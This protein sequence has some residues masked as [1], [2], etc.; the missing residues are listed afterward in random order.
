MVRHCFLRAAVFTLLSTSP[1]ICPQ[2][3]ANDWPTWRHD[4]L[5]TGVTSERVDPPLAQVWAFRSRQARLSPKP[6]H[7]PHQAKYPWL[8]WYTLPITA[9]GDGLFFN[10]AA[11]GRTVCLD[12]AT[13]KVRWEFTAGAAVNRT[14]MIWQHK[15]YVGSDDGHVYCL[16]A[17]AGTVVW[18]FKAAPADRWL[19]CY[20]KPVSV[21]PVRTDVLVDD[22]VAYFGAGVFPHD[23]TLLYAVDAR[24]GKLL[25]RNGTQCETGWRASMAPAGHLFVTEKS[26]WVPKDCWGYFLNWGTLVAFDR[27]TG[28]PMRSGPDKGEWPEWPNMAGPFWPVFGVRK[29]GVRYF[30]THASKIDDKD[31]NKQTQLWRQDVEGRWTDV[32][33][34]ISVRY[35]NPVF[36]RY[37]PDLSTVVYA[38]GVLYHTALDLDPKKGTASGI[39]ARDPASGKLLWS[40]EVAERAN[41]LIVA[42]GRLF[43]ATRQGTIYAFAPKGA[44]EYGVI[45]EAIDA[46]A[47][48][49][50][51]GP[52]PAET[53]ATAEAIIKETG[54]EAG[55]ALVVDCNRGGLALEL[56]KRTKLYVVAAFPDASNAD[57]ARKVYARANLHV[58]RIVAYHQPPGTKLPLPSF[59][60]DLVVSEAATGGGAL[61]Q[62]AENLNR[63]LKPIRGVALIGGKQNEG[64]LGEW[65]AATKQADWAIVKGSSVWAKRVRPRLEEAGGWFHPYGD[66]GHSNC[67]R[68][69]ALKPPLGV[70]WYGA[71]HLGEGSGSPGGDS[72]VVDGILLLPEGTTLTGYDQYTGR[73]LWRRENGHT[74]TVAAPGSV[75]LRYLEV[76]IQI[77]PATGRTLQEYHPP[78]T[79]GK[80]TAMAA[81]RDGKT[82]YLAAGGEQWNCTLAMDVA[83]GK[84]RWTLGGPGKEKQW[85]AWSAIGDGYIYFGGGEAEGTLREEVIAEMRAY[86][87]AD[88]PKRLEKFEEELDQHEFRTFTTVDAKTGKVLYTHGMDATNCGGKWLPAVG[89][90]GG[91]YARHYNPLVFGC[92]IAQKDVVIF[93]TASG[94][95]KGWRQWPAGAYS[96]RSIAVHDGAT[97]KLLWKKPADY[98]TRPVVVDDTIYAEPWAYDLRT[99]ERKTRIHP[100]TGKQADWA[101]CRSDKQC[102]IFSAS[103]HFLFGRSL[104]VGYHDLLTDQGLYTFFHS[105]MS[106]SFDALSGGGLMIKPPMA[107]YCKCSWSLP[108]T[109]ALGQVPTQPTVGQLYAQPGPVLP[110]KHL[111]V[112]FGATG[113]RRDVQGDLWLKPQRPEGHKLLLGFGLTV[114]MYPGGED[115]RRNSLYTPIENTEVPFVFATAARG[116]KRCIIP[117]T[118]S[119]DGVG[120]F[121]VK[122]GFAA[123][124]GDKPGRRVFDVKLNGKTVL[125]DFDVVKEAGRPDV[126]V[127]KDFVLDLDGD[128]VLDLVARSDKPTAEQMPL[129]N[130]LVIRRQER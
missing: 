3:R 104:G 21:W 96:Q 2:G 12:A 77:D 11:D 119:A 103:K 32:D 83:G 74:D 50:G 126:A 94:A 78:F 106:C 68:D 86:L 44:K 92:T 18:K 24:T 53:A 76:V 48:V 33:S 10:S 73:E 62:D 19:L 122:L 5:R 98:R 40:A 125:K 55:Y 49:A 36:F 81:D 124:P 61:P 25:W 91:R 101:W 16:D 39:Y 22:G 45:E 35:K 88:D 42:N 27:A 58:S 89:Y 115:V 72:R 90:G 43:A 112:D 34:V 37:D 82:L 28:G 56:A 102:G 29:D 100:I 84:P 79:G 71:P 64:T 120:V 111:Y 113:D 38:G 123:L 57:A 23:G 54:A 15:V 1:A 114:E 127:W 93:C 66:A 51:D 20:G 46:G 41:Q 97:G 6:Q 75:F 116:L 129:I 110:V 30:G 13:G 99:G 26:I 4:R 47:V 14:P 8:T 80:W 118:T 117:V 9:A 59:F 108:F 107:V 69:G 70:L 95:D 87:K 109:V 60:A 130:G 85:G 31:P 52:A 67:S 17:K 65:I 105:R 7:S 63:M 121:K 128:L